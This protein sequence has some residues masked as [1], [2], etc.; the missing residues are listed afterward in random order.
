L[1]ASPPFPS[2]PPRRF[3]YELHRFYRLE[4]LVA[5]AWFVVFAVVFLRPS[6]SGPRQA[7]FIA[8]WIVVGIWN[9]YWLLTRIAYKIEVDFPLL[10]WHTPLREGEILIQ[11]I[12]AVRPRRFASSTQIIQ[13]DA[14]Q[15]IMVPVGKGMDEFVAALRSINPRITYKPSPS[16]WVTELSWVR[17]RFHR[18]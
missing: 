13:T 12:V 14:G 4:M 8:V 3:R 1:T 2:P 11:D 16:S 15:R 10:R 6:L 17:S 7:W 5:S 18:D 9:G